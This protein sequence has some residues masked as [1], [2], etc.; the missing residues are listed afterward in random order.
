MRI[1]LQQTSGTVALYEIQEQATQPSLESQ[2]V[3]AVP[4]PQTTSPTPERTCPPDTMS[5]M[6]TGYIVALTIFLAYI[7]LLMRRVASVRK[8]S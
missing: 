3:D 7:V 4:Q 8:T 1:A 5:S 2:Q 6:K